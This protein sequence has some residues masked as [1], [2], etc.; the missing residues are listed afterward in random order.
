MAWQGIPFIHEHIVSNNYLTI[1][2]V[3]KIIIDSVFSWESSLITILGSLIAGAIPA[4]IAWKAIENSNKLLRSQMEL[5]QAT[6]RQMSSHWF[7][8]SQWQLPNAEQYAVLQ[9]LFSR[10]AAEKHQQGVLSKPHHDLVA[11]YQI[12]NR[13]YSELSLEYESLRRPFAVTADVPYTDV[14]TFPSVA[15]YPGKHPCEKPADLMEHIIRSSSRSG[16][17]VADFFLGSG[18]T[19]KA[20]IKLGRVGIGVEL[21]EERFNQTVEEIRSLLT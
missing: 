4:I 12:L 18:A 10:I 21:E 9:N 20:A 19:L 16:D 11:E 8:E 7:S 14:W 1:S 13:Q 2:K 15:F 6:G 3:P 17:V 5:A